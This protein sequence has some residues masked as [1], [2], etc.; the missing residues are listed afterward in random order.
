V[1]KEDV[2]QVFAPLSQSNLHT[3]DP[4]SI[5]FDTRGRRIKLADQARVPLNLGNIQAI[6]AALP[7]PSDY[8]NGLPNELVLPHYRHQ[9]TCL[10]EAGQPFNILVEP[11]EGRVVEA[12][13]TA[14]E[15]YRPEELIESLD[16]A[17][18]PVDWLANT[19]TL[20]HFSFVGLG[21]RETA[22]SVGDI[23]RVGIQVSGSLIGFQALTIELVAY[24]LRCT[25]GMISAEHRGRRW[26]RSGD[27]EGDDD[28]ARARG[29]Y[30]WARRQM[31]KVWSGADHLLADVQRS[32]E[33]PLEEG[34]L[35]NFDRLL[36]QHQVP[37]R[38]AIM[39]LVTEEPPQTVYD[40][41]QHMTYVAS[42][43]SMGRDDFGWA[44]KVYRMQ[45][46]AGHFLGHLTSCPTCHQVAIVEED[47]DQ[48]P[49]IDAE[50]TVVEEP[51]PVEE[52]PKPKRKR[53]AKKAASE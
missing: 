37:Q 32:A 28:D 53:R 9:L 33:T 22:V 51:E 47:G 29:T 10:A 3:V 13:T 30:H 52:A 19:K 21:S 35:D 42:H 49:V 5:E 39:K 7:V 20:K 16:R 26:R 14:L 15:P 4:A 50:A 40:L 6:G 25:N 1:N 2:L 46:L 17:I 38:R 27:G 36:A 48:E 12:S 8:F 24:R 23:T 34:V 18:Q 43:T 45:R 31:R 44:F 41:L 11:S